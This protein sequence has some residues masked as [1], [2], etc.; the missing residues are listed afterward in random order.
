[1]TLFLA[2]CVLRCKF[3]HNPDTWK[4]R[5]CAMHTID[6]VMARITRYERI[7]KTVGGGVTISGGEPIMQPAF[8]AQV[9][10]RCKELGIH[11][12]IHTSGQLS[13]STSDQLL[14]DPDQV[15]LN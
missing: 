1:M 13:T 7:F 6:E 5:D 14:H 12:T 8:V 2:G 4:M 9:L 10:R 11:N 15:M 3:C